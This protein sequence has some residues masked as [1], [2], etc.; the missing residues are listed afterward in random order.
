VRIFPLSNIL[1]SWITEPVLSLTVQLTDNSSNQTKK[2]KLD[3]TTMNTWSI[4]H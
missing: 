1:Y 3:L 2:Q 4:K